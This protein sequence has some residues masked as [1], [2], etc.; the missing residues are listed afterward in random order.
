[1]LALVEDAP[2]TLELVFT[3]SHKEPTYLLD[4]ADLVTEVRK[5]KHPIDAGQP[6]RKGTEY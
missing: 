5:G 4:H 6:A 2:D 3:G 1:M